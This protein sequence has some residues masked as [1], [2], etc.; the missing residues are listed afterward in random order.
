MECAPAGLEDVMAG[1]D[2]KSSDG[3]DPFSRCMEDDEFTRK[4]LERCGKTAGCDC[5]AFMEQCM[6]AFHDTSHNK[7]KGNGE[8]K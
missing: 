8:K 2:E 6:S 3:R 5:M 4:M 7:E 1:K